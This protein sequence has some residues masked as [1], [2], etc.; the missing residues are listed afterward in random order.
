MN[1][2]VRILPLLVVAMFTSCSPAK[3]EQM[4]KIAFSENKEYLTNGI[5]WSN[6]LKQ[7]D[8]HYLVFFYSPTCNH[9]EEIIEDVQEF[10]R[11]EIVKLYYLN[12]KEQDEKIPV[13]NEIKSTI[14][15]SDISDLFIAGTPTI[16][17]VFEGVV[18][19]NVAGKEACLTLL[20]E[21]RLLQKTNI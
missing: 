12:I 4:S 18:K 5:L 8:Q 14:G 7:I 15:V 2:R 10:A 21:Q 20:N 19:D 11:S 1:H 16:I 6:C 13:S 3:S 9:C 17:E